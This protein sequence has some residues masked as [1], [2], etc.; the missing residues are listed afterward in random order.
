[1]VFTFI[2]AFQ[3]LDISVTQQSRDSNAKA[4]AL[5]QRLESAACSVLSSSSAKQPRSPSP[6]HGASSS[7]RDPPRHFHKS[8]GGQ[9]PVICAICL[10]LHTGVSAC[11]TTTLWNG[12]ATCIHKRSTGSI[13]TKSGGCVCLNWQIPRGCT[14]AF[15]SDC[16]NCSGCGSKDH[17]AYKCPR[18]QKE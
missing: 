2:M 9:S 18:A 4:Q 15:H 6:Q 13:E 7:R 12:G 14:S 17:G 8:T 11:R 16:H 10:G 3:C 1:M 5:L